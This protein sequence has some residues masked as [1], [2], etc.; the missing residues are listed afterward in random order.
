M[1]LS[2]T[3][4]EILKKG[5][6][7]YVTMSCLKTLRKY[8][9]SL[10]PKPQDYIVNDQVIGKFYDPK[11]VVKNQVIDVLEHFYGLCPEKVPSELWMHG[12][13]VGDGFSGEV[14][15]MGGD[16]DLYTYSRYIIGSKL[17]RFMGAP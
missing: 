12:G 7:P 15:R 10:V 6:A 17:A 5:F 13:F 2:D 8:T 11:E 16:K 4:Y 3:D 9:S 1:R 14:E